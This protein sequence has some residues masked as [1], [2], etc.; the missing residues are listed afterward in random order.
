MK[1]LA[2]L[3]LLLSLSGCFS[4]GVVP[5]GP[6]TYM[7]N[8]KAALPGSYLK[9]QLYTEGNAYCQKA[10]KVFLPVREQWGNDFAEIYFRCLNPD[11]AELKRPTPQPIPN[12][13]I[14]T[15]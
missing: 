13:R 9:G 2:G 3:L 12:L 4:S 15:R 14:Q 10:E 7:M 11:D 1:T 8:R 5:V 6:D